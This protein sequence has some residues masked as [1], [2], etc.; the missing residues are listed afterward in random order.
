MARN[1]SAVRRCPQE[2]DGGAFSIRE[3]RYLE[4]LPAVKHVIGD[5]I[6]YTDRF[7]RYCIA[8]Y[9]HGD[10]PQRIFYDAGLDS[11]LIGYKRVERC[12]AR[13][14]H[15]VQGSDDDIADFLGTAT[16]V[17]RRLYDTAT[18]EQ[19]EASDANQTE[20]TPDGDM[21]DLMLMQQA[22]RIAELERQ[23]KDLYGQI[24]QEK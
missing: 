9:N 7:K 6:T 16:S 22:R 8:R 14:K 2:Y 19:R 21:R 15:S 3:R 17:A 13:W 11:Q 10:S 1:K 24:H 12:I 5:R 18:T 4:S 20:Q 23:L